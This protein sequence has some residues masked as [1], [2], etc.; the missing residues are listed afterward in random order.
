MHNDTCRDLAPQGLKVFQMKA[1][2]GILKDHPSQQVV[3]TRIS[4]Y[5]GFHEGKRL[6]SIIRI[7]Q[8]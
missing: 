4:T 2:K 5:R 3:S 1:R 7:V 6:F 8:A